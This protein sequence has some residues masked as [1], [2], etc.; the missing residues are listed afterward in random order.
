MTT[1][2]KQKVFRYKPKY[3]V[4]EHK[5]AEL[6]AL[7]L[8]VLDA[9]QQVDQYQ[10]IVTALTTKLNNFQALLNTAETNREGA[11]SNKNLVDQVVQNFLDLQNTSGVAFNAMVSADL[12]TKKLAVTVRD[13]MNKLIFAAEVINKLGT[14][15]V[16]KKAMNPLVSDELVS[17]MTVAGNDAN[18]AVA[19]MLV[20]LQSTYTA[21]ASNMEAE[22]AAVL[23][24]YESMEVY[25]FLSGTDET[26]QP[27]KN[28][29]GT[30]AEAYTGCLQQ[31]LHTAYRNAKLTY[32]QMNRATEATTKELS[33]AQMAL[34]EAQ[35]T[36]AALQAGLA[37][38][39]AAALAS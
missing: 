12:Q 21:Q 29:D 39:N 17:L 34:S 28:P 6:D 19:L 26:G 4:T 23:E 14:Q 35:G 30:P 2:A 11:L 10:A 18:N 20:A 24:Y 31:L 5:K 9:Q 33:N 37:A 16:R 38:G 7:T 15:V 32:E 8:E 36:L 1:I 3:G 25:R 22:A 13:V 27:A